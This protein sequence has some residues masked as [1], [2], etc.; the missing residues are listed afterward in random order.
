[1]YINQPPGVVQNLNFFEALQLKTSTIESNDGLKTYL[2]LLESFIEVPEP[3]IF[4]Q[5]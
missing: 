4:Q 1:M 2:K 5:G 3:I